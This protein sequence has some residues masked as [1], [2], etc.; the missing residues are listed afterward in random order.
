MGYI[1]HSEA[2][3]RGGRIRT[4]VRADRYHETNIAIMNQCDSHSSPAS[5][6]SCPSIGNWLMQKSGF[7]LID[8][9]GLLPNL[10]E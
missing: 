9:F 8:N 7:G 10:P 5:E 6:L 4:L 1:P 3:H 2:A